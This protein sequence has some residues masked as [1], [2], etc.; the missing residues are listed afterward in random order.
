MI[1]APFIFILTFISHLSF[2]QNL[3][4]QKFNN[5]K[6]SN[7][8]LG[9]GETKAE[10]PQTFK[11]EFIK[12]LGIKNLNK[13]NGEIELQILIDSFGNPCL[14]SANNQTNIKSNKLNL[15]KAVNN[16]PVWKPAI[17]EKIITQ[18]SVTLLLIFKNCIAHMVKYESSSYSQCN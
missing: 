18:S 13:I 11:K 12:I 16:S 3:Y 17:N 6:L 8:C 7:F 4:T 1:R 2:G 15:Q 14:L 10:I 5:C 9:C